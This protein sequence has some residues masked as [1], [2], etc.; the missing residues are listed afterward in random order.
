ME[1]TGRKGKVGAERLSFKQG[2]LK[3]NRGYVDDRNREDVL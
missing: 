1:M 3:P 2:T